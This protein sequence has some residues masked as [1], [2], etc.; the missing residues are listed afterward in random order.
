MA[1]LRRLLS[2]SWGL[3]S[4]LTDC[5]VS[6]Y[7]FHLPHNGI[8]ETL[9][10]TQNLVILGLIWLYDLVE[11]C[12]FKLV[13]VAFFKDVYKLCFC[14]E[15]VSHFVNSSNHTNHLCDFAIF[16]EQKNELSFIEWFH[17][18]AILLTTHLTC[19][20]SSIDRL[21]SRVFFVGI[22]FLVFFVLHHVDFNVVKTTYIQA[23]SFSITASWECFI[24]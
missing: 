12:I 11:V 15:S 3:A 9:V 16:A 14:Y 1:L 17:F 18:L 22:N 2:S 24:E 20:A 10:V 21:V 7:H 13:W 4:V 6:V 23:L 19:E 5:K 8:D